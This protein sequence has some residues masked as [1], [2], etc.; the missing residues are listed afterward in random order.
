MKEQ[1]LDRT[2]AYIRSKCSVYDVN[3]ANDYIKSVLSSM[4][5]SPISE[6]TQA[7]YTYLDDIYMMRQN[8]MFFVTKDFDSIRNSVHFVCSAAC[9]FKSSVINGVWTVYW[10]SMD[11]YPVTDSKQLNVDIKKTETILNSEPSYSN[12]Y[13]N[14]KSVYELLRIEN[15]FYGRTLRP[16]L[17][18]VVL[19]PSLPQTALVGNPPRK[20]ACYNRFISSGMVPPP[21][22]N[23]LVAIKGTWIADIVVQ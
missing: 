17:W 7:L 18:L 5:N 12:Y 8:F 1:I 19:Y 3:K 11:V 4:Q 20:N 10:A 2:L 23:F 9:V 6:V 15:I 14:A 13:R 21:P 22:R 16:E